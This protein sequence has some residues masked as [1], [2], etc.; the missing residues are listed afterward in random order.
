M[1]P[2]SAQCRTT[3]EAKLEEAGRDAGHRR[4]LIAA[5]E[6]W[7]FLAS[8]LRRLEKT[9]GVTGRKDTLTSGRVR[10]ALRPTTPAREYPMVTY[11]HR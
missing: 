4:R 6:G 1:L 5:A 8:Q 9:L 11:D 7:L 3:A 10:R 2:T